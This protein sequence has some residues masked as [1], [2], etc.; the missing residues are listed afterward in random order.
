MPPTKKSKSKPQNPKVLHL[1]QVMTDYYVLAETCSARIRNLPNMAQ[2]Y[3]DALE[4]WKKMALYRPPAKDEEARA[5]FFSA[6]DKL[7]KTEPNTPEKYVPN[8]CLRAILSMTSPNSCL[9]VIFASTAGLQI[10]VDQD[11]V[12]MSEPDRCEVLRESGLRAY[13]YAVA[14]SFRSSRSSLYSV[15]R[16]RASNP[17]NVSHPASLSSMNPPPPPHL[18]PVLFP[19]NAEPDPDTLF[20]AQIR[21]R[22][23]KTGKVMECTVDD[24]VTSRLRG[25]YF[26]ITYADGELDE[27]SES[28]I[29]EMLKNRIQE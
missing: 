29:R 18:V 11:I 12:E 25:K 9:M 3:D 20:G 27:V 5:K 19:S 6:V 13:V 14:P 24:C 21:Y 26:I 8:P 28:D 1:I 16:I 17:S 10:I 2:L 7:C 23:A 4:K 15:E 22:D